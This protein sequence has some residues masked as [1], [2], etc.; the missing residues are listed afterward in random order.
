MTSRH[1]CMLAT[2]GFYSPCQLQSDWLGHTDRG[3][4]WRGQNEQTADSSQDDSPNIHIIN[5]SCLCMM[6]YY[7]F[8]WIQSKGLYSHTLRP[9][10]YNYRFCN[11]GLCN[12]CSKSSHFLKLNSEIIS[13]NTTLLIQTTQQPTNLFS[14]RLHIS[15]LYCIWYTIS[16]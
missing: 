15:T 8:S 3:E 11:R 12:V 10:H 7:L 9:H 6:L 5:K 14:P 13:I 1:C 4:G 2:G 16:K